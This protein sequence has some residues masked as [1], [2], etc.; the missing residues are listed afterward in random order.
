MLL[1]CLQTVTVDISPENTAHNFISKIVGR[2]RECVQCKKDGRRTPRGRAR[3]TI[4]QVRTMRC[5]ALQRP[6]C[7]FSFVYVYVFVSADFP[8]G[9]VYTVHV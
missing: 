5:C 6:T 8:A 1:F 2:K 3:E 4:M 9:L 7:M